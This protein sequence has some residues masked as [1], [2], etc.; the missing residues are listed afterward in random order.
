MPE[1]QPQSDHPDGAR[2]DRTRADRARERCHELVTKYYPRDRYPGPDVR[3]H[4]LARQIVEPGHVVLDAGCGRNLPLTRILGSQARFAVGV[5]LVDF[6]E[7]PSPHRACRAD[8]GRTP[9]RDESFDAIFTKSVVEHL[10]EPESVFREFRRI[11]RPGG[12]VVILTPNALDYVSLVARV[13]PLWVHQ[14]LIGRFLGWA[15]KDVFDTLYRANTSGSLRSALGRAGLQ[16]KEIELFNQYPVYFMF[17]PI[18][19]RLGVV[20]ERITTRIKALAALR[21]WILAIATR[22]PV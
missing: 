21:G 7:S 14:K 13:T 22:D 15:E 18:L 1:D 12:T 9:F 2:S 11:L 10:E 3:L 8:L 5:D 19:F 16:V 20:Y 4:A 17:S 6:D